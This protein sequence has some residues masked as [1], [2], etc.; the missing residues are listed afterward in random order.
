MSTIYSWYSKNICWDGKDLFWYGF[1]LKRYFCPEIRIDRCWNM[2]F[3]NKRYTTVQKMKHF[4]WEFHLQKGTNSLQ[5]E[6][7]FMK[8]E[9]ILC[10]NNLR[11]EC[12]PLSCE[13]VAE[14]DTS[15]PLITSCTRPCSSAKP[16]NYLF[17]KRVR[18]HFV[19][20]TNCPTFSHATNC[21]SDKMSHWCTHKKPLFHW[22]QNLPTTFHNFHVHKCISWDI[23]SPG[24]KW[25]ILS[26][27]DN[28]S[29]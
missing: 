17:R 14:R 29:P 10:G 21:P 1:V 5:I 27:W 6:K 18:R 15:P 3:H 2:I 20:T 9:N 23:L 24:R 12:S 25:D 16:S 19:P 13:Q 22:Q 28:L 26:S 11:R 8:I 4:C 7:I